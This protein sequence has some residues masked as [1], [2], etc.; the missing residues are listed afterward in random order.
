MDSHKWVESYQGFSAEGWRVQMENK[1]K[2]STRGGWAVL[3]FSFGFGLHFNSRD[4]TYIK[5]K[6]VG[7]L[8]NTFNTL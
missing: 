8:V 6:M 4:Y 1:K 7:L 3:P 5:N 2:S